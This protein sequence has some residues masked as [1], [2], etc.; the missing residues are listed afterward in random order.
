M[1]GLLFPI[2]MLAVTLV[3]GGIFLL[4][5]KHQKPKNQNSGES[6]AIRT[7]QEFINVRDVKDKYLYTKDGLVLVFLRV[8]SISI[9]LYSKSEK[10]SLIRQL[11]AELS[12]I[13]YPFKFMAVSRPVDIS[14]LIADMQSMLKDA[15]DKQKE[16]L[17][18]EILQMSGYALSGEIV[19]RQFYISLWEKYEDGSAM[20]GTE[21]DLFKRASLLAEKFSGNGIG[22]D[23][24]TEKEII[25]LLNLVNN[26][27]YTHLEDTEYSASV[28][29]L[30]EDIYA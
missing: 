23:V 3:G 17:R 10:N 20:D 24:L 16:L 21:K 18:Q 9:D 25:R 6:T 27:S 28:P 2:I 4:V 13:Q 29:T 14:P 1:E 12:D 30:K 11:T 19:E 5:L 7:A 15:G 26:P 8:H 22:C